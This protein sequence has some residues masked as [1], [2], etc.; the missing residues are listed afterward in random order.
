MLKVYSQPAFINACLR[1]VTTYYFEDKVIY[2]LQQNSPLCCNYGYTTKFDI[3]GHTFSH[4][5]VCFAM[6]RTLKRVL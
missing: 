3:C 5:A 6:F 1:Y 4:S 2:Y